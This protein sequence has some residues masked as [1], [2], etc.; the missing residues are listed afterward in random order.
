MIQEILGGLP[1]ITLTHKKR[2]SSSGQV[3]KKYFEIDF[4]KLASLEATPA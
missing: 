2:A 1:G 3:D 4:N